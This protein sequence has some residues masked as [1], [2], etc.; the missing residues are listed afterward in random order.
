MKQ[1]KTVAVDSDGELVIT[2]DDVPSNH[3]GQYKCLQ[4]EGYRRRKVPFY[5]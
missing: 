4:G 1:N 5:V 2:S 3:F